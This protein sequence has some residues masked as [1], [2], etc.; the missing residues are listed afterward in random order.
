VAVYDNTS[1]QPGPDFGPPPGQTATEIQT[2]TARARMAGSGGPAQKAPDFQ[3]RLATYQ[4]AG[5][6]QIKEISKQFRR[7]ARDFL[8][9]PYPLDDLAALMETSPTHYACVHAKASAVSA[10]GWKVT[11][12]ENEMALHAEALRLAREEKRTPDEDKRMRSILRQLVRLSDEE[13]AL[14]RFFNTPNPDD[15]FQEIN[16]RT[17]VDIESLGNGYWEVVRDYGGWPSEIYHMPGISVRL[18]A[19]MTGVAQVRN[20]AQTPFPAMITP[21]SS[22]GSG[23][24]VVYFKFFGKPWVMDWR[25]GKIYGTLI[26]TKDA[27]AFVTDPANQDKDG[28]PLYALAD[29]DGAPDG[30]RV[31]WLVKNDGSIEVL[32]PHLW[33]NE[34]IWWRKYSVKNGDGY[35]IP[36]IV[37]ALDATAGDRGAH[38]SQLDFFENYAVPRAVF[39]MKGFPPGAP[40]E[41]GEEGDVAGSTDPLTLTSDFF[42]RE[43]RGQQHRTLVLES[44][45]DIKNADGSVTPGG[46][47]EFVKV[48][49]EI[50]DASHLNYLKN[51]RDEIMR[52]ERVPSE[53]IASFDLSTRPASSG[54]SIGL[55][56]FKAN[57][58]RPMQES[59]ERK[60]NKLVQDGFGFDWSFEFNDVDT[61][62]EFRAI[63]GRTGVIEKRLHRHVNAKEA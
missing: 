16:Y 35:G 30:F 20:T 13:K 39:F 24:T 28:H 11:P 51:N 48:S 62:D 27:Q 43:L 54:M 42:D 19:N 63:S 56:V 44:P 12:N 7:N 46:S 40:P 38:R 17:D 10:N 6:K 21:T 58:V 5:T 2:R 47:V 22:G 3:D 45:P 26:L 18:L 37:S 36:D 49:D 52:A 8:T 34:V 4:S 14:T 9:T 31:A 33:A 23:L 15:T 41:E 25:T 53:M 57:V 59:R 60:V 32:P 61:L 29:E 1:G 50:Q 55:E